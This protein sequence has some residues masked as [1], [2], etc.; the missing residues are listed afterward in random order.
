MD[1]KHCFELF[2][3][4]YDKFDDLFDELR[5]KL[6]RE[7]YPIRMPDGTYHSP[8]PIDLYGKSALYWIDI[9][10]FT[11]KFNQQI[12]DIDSLLQQFVAIRN[13]LNVKFEQLRIFRQQHNHLPTTLPKR[14]IRMFLQNLID[15]E[16]ALI[17]YNPQKISLSKLG[18]LA[19][20]AFSKR[21]H[22]RSNKS[23]FEIEFYFCQVSNFS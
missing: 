8:P 13:K 3:K 21:I 5:M 15:F 1:T 17:E 11:A 16:A 23:S 4:A 14:R 6:L 22:D 19:L 20:T 9:S 18:F 2:E 10:I 12:D 7:P